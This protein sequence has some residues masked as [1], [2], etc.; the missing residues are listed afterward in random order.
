LAGGLFL[1]Y[2]LPTFAF[3][4]YNRDELKQKY[5]GRC[6]Y[7]G[8]LLEGKWHADHVVPV[9]RTVKYITTP[10]G[11]KKKVRVFENPELDTIENLVPAC[12]SCNINKHSMTVEQFRDSIY[13]YVES[14]NKRMVQYQM[15][16]K[17]NLI[18]ETGLPIKFYY[19]TRQERI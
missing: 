15:A 19:E 9:R 14:L 6:A 13:Q 10:D 5:E 16:K 17:Y 18:T 7:C 8:C 3:M 12:A 1:S 4:K 11:F 2:S